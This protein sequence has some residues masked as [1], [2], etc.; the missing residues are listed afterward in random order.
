MTLS[1]GFVAAAFTLGLSCAPLA[2]GA[3]LTTGFGA[4]TTGFTFS[5]GVPLGTHYDAR[6]QYGSF[7]YNT[8]VNSSD[9]AYKGQLQLR[10]L[11][12]L[13]D[14]HPFGST[15][16]LATGF[17][18]P[19]FSLAA[20]AIP[21]SDGSFTLNNVTF[22]G[23]NTVGGTIAWNKTA[24]YLG[25]A[26]VPTRDRSGLSFAADLG[27]AFIGS[28]Q[29]NIVA[30]GPGA[31]NPAVQSAI[32]QEKQSIQNSSNFRVFPVVNVGLVYRFGARAAD[33]QEPPVQ[34]TPPPQHGNIFQPN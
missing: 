24:P 1:R 6:V 27:A 13:A 30:T 10:S 21:N 11:M 28:P 23:L 26:W 20:S 25:V 3:E 8:S 29:V 7:S 22:T 19:N 5:L 15:F 12:M 33:N 16:A 17:C 9:N 4:G 32:A 14:Y 31:F 18:F 2:A 34:Q